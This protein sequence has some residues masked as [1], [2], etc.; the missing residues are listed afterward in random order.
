MAKILIVEDEKDLRDIYEEV[1]KEANFEVITATNGK[2]ALK[3]L[4]NEKIDLMLLDLMM[5]E[6]DGMEVLKVVRAD[7]VKYGQ[8]KVI[9]LTNLSSD[10]VIKESF[11]AKAD[12][13][14]MK[15]EL[16]PQ[17]IVDEVNGFLN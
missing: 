6:M 3:L 8:L 7:S 13:Y 17:Q 15:A 2:E 16:T 4:N 10:I 14:L 12:G 9:V 1:L 11:E 5:P